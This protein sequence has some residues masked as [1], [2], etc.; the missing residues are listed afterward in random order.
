MKIKKITS[1]HRRDFMA[2]YECEHCS[3]T[4]KGGGYDDDNFHVNVVPNMECG[5]CGKTARSEY[6]A[7]ETKY[8]STEVI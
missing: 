1:Q 3:H 8:K 6:R 4:E 7:R 2:V 5:K